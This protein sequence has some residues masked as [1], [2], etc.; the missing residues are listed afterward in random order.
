ME[1]RTDGGLEQARDCCE[2]RPDEVSGRSAMRLAYAE[3]FD[4]VE[5]FLGNISFEDSIRGAIAA[6]EVEFSFSIW[7][8]LTV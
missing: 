8:D 3:S 5:N 6:F 2:D 7:F 4:C 1:L